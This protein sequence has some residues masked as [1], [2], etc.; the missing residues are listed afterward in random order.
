MRTVW[1]FPFEPI[2]DFQLHMPLNAEIVLIDVHPEDGPCIWATVD[3]M[4]PREW[5]RFMCT[6][7]GQEQPHMSWHL[8]TFIVPPYVWHLWGA[9]P[10][11]VPIDPPAPAVLARMKPEE[12]RKFFGTCHKVQGATGD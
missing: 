1:K 2:G 4:M 10:D 5:R 3:A 9:L 8:K 11:V 12:F 7:T 6:R